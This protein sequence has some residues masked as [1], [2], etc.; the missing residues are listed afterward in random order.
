MI[1]EIE[2]LSVIAVDGGMC[3]APV[4]RVV[5]VRVVGVGASCRPR[6]PVNSPERS[7]S[8]PS[9]SPSSKRHHLDAVGLEVMRAI[10]AHPA[11]S[12]AGLV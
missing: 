3:A 7:T 6:M 1:G 4:Q 2:S 11:P 10:A 8:I 9:P 5:V 12:V